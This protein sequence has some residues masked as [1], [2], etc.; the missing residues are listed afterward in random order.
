MHIFYFMGRQPDRKF[1]LHKVV[2]GF[3][4]G[5]LFTFRNP[6]SGIAGCH[7]SYSGMSQ[8]PH[9]ASVTGV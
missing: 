5:K 3:Y 4:P 6:V 1:L 9:P 7:V 8:E 2:S